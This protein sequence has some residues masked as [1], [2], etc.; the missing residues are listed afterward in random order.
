MGVSAFGRTAV[1]ILLCHMGLIEVL[2]LVEL[3]QPEEYFRI[4]L[5]PLLFSSWGVNLATFT[6]TTKFHLHLAA[7]HGEVGIFHFLLHFSVKILIRFLVESHLESLVFSV[8]PFASADVRKG[9]FPD[10]A[11]SLVSSV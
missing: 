9:C 11:S 6:K 5:P 2:L 8:F 4:Y 3:Y 1:V 10:R 7:R